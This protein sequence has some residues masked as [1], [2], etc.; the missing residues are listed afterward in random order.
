MTGY[1]QIIIKS[2]NKAIGIEYKVVSVDTALAV[3][4][5]PRARIILRDGKRAQQ[6][7]SYSDK[8][9]FDLGKGVEILIKEQAKSETL[10]SVFKGTVVKHSLKKKGRDTFLIVDL[11]DPAVMMTSM[12]KTFVYQKKTD[13][14]IIKAIVNRYKDLAVTTIDKAA[15]KH[16]QMIQYNVSDWDFMLARAEANGLWVTVSGG[17]FKFIK[18][19]S[20]EVVSTYNY[21]ISVIDEFELQADIQQQLNKVEAASWDVTKQEISKPAKANPF[22]V[23]QDSKNAVAAAKKFNDATCQLASYTDLELDEIQ[24]WADAKLQKNRLSLFQGHLKVPGYT[25]DSK[26][27]SRKLKPGD[28]IKIEGTSKYFNG[29]QLVSAV[30]HQVTSQGWKITIHFGCSASWSYEKYSMSDALA[31][32][33]LPGIN[34]LQIGI[35]EAFK[36]DPDNK[37]RIA[38]SIPAYTDSKSASASAGEA[39][40]KVFF[41]RLGMPYATKEAGWFFIPEKGDEVILGFFNDDPR[42]P[43]ILGSLYNPKNKIPLPLTAENNQKAMVLKKDETGWLFDAKEKTFALT[44]SKE[45]SI[46]IKDGEM[47]EAKVKEETIKINKGISLKAKEDIVLDGKNLN[48]KA[49]AGI[50][51]EASNAYDIKGNKVNIKGSQVEVS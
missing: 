51:S 16:E 46:N 24:A 4:K 32:G 37:F 48:Q 1:P 15:V 13:A 6:K 44:T 40:K 7:F 14:E 27:K 35:V 8:G 38:V 5:I 18:P 33:L 31:G 11:K 39:A 10:T 25:I 23:P 26:D 43:V 34:G 17:Q 41:A 49:S 29:K 45:T 12:R 20:G 36:A 28:T 50:K 30:S 42:Y 19:K 3:N 22:T 2:S 21:G 47:F 9:D